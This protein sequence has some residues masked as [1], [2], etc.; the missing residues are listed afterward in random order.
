MQSLKE[1]FLSCFWMCTVEAVP[2]MLADRGGPTGIDFGQRVPDTI[3]MGVCY[4]LSPF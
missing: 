4:T 2:P 3:F 1:D